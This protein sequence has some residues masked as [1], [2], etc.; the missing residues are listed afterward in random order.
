VDGAAERPVVGLFGAFD[1]G[2]LGEVALR[3]VIESEITRRR[4]DIDLI[5]L[6]PF[7]AER[8]VPGD[9]GR[10]ARP[11]P[12]IASADQLD[13][14]AL[15]IAGDVLGDDRH[16]AGR[17]PAPDEAMAARGVGTLVLTGARQGRDLASS[18]TWFAVGS[19][20]GDVDLSGLEGKNVWAR[21][22][23]TQER[24][25]GTAVQSGDPVLLSARVFASEPLRR[26]ADLL[27]LCGAIPAGPRMV[28][29]TS[30]GLPAAIGQRLAAAMTAALRSDPKLSVVV[31]D[32]NP[33]R[34]PSGESIPGVRGL[35]AERVHH[36]PSWAGLD[37]IAAAMSGSLAAVASTPAG[38]NLAASL[39][40]SVLAMGTG[41][42]HRFDPVIPL[43]GEDVPPAIQ[44]LLAG[45]HPA[46]IDTA[47]QT[48]DG[49][50]AELAQRLPRTSRATEAAPMPDDVASALGVL[51]RR[52]VD[53]RTALQAEIS[54]VQ[55][56]LDHLRASPEHRLARPI[57]EGYQRWQR[58]RT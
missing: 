18:V 25:G 11:L 14:D 20:G 8:S 55:A 29:E 44:E 33:T 21:D 28:I 48:L 49:A 52:L 1:T 23:A 56:E 32:L 30:S 40:V 42:G 24:L 27:R 12:R 54:R 9:E 7:G 45:K 13:L 10:P 46:S 16:W 41:R 43:L 22:P 5:T 37:D 34:E 17:Y 3:R 15:I 19:A 50:F 26:R 4:P 6:A 57:R 53:E 38:A 39:G 36:L 35:I 58:R 47:I 2:E 31:V 51:Q